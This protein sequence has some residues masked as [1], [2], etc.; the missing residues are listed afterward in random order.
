MAGQKDAYVRVET[1]AE[2]AVLLAETSIASRL[3]A[4]GTDLLVVAHKEGASWDRLVDV[5]RVEEM[6]GIY[7]EAGALYVGAAVTHAEVADSR[8]IREQV[9]ALAE[10]SH[11]VGSPQI[12]NRGTLGGNI[13]NAAACADTLPALVCLGAVAEIVTPAGQTEMPV[14]ELVT[15]VNRTALPADGVIRR[16]RIP[17]PPAGSRT[18]FVKLG[19]RQAQSISRLSLA[20]LGRLDDRGLAA[21]V[22]LTPGACTSQTQ[23]FSAAE[24]VLLG[25]APTDALA[26]EAGAAAAAQMVAIAGRRW[27]TAY[28][29]P[30]LTALVERALR[31][32]FDIPEEE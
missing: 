2:A 15:G 24:A 30:A 11:S 5:S 29:E 18:A 7:E 1:C 19:R 20:C 28:K 9:P 3:L 21:D 31:Q 8:L 13:A 26:R 17:K 10:A 16:F 23:R 25:K 14:S 22:R 32:V 4:G 12:R 27:S 6:Q